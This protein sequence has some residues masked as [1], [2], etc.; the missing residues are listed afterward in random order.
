MVV[1]TIALGLFKSPGEL[2]ADIVVGEGQPLGIPMSF[3]GPY[4]GFFATRMAYVRKIAG[5]IVGETV[6]V[7][8]RRAYVMTLRPRE[9]DI[10][11]EKA[12]SNI[13]TN[14]GLMA[15]AAC[16]YISV[17][18]KHGLR[19][20]AELCYH[21]AHY[22]A[23]QIN[24]LDGYSVDTSKPFFKEFVVTCPKPAAEI[25]EILL[26]HWGIIGGYD[27][28]KDYDKRENQMLLAVTEMNTKDEID[29]LVEALRDA[30]AHDHTGHSH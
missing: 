26:E 28:S 21:K 14:Q 6:D 7:H 27:L 10:R 9:Q 25:N 24:A 17:M 11:R 1:D 15:L 30:K 4:L 18:G 23:E 8:G 16:V 3:G 19:K 22:A 20:V 2:G 5:R 29:T 12:T 13:C